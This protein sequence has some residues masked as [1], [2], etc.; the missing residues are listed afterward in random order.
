MLIDHFCRVLQVLLLLHRLGNGL[1]EKVKVEIW[2][3]LR[4]PNS[5]VSPKS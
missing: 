1:R 2:T 5:W 4:V 3:N